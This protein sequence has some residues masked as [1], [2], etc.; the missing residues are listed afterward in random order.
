MWC[1]RERVAL[2]VPQLLVLVLAYVAA[3]MCCAGRPTGV[4]KLMTSSTLVKWC[5]CG[6]RVA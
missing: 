2:A 1:R 5:S 3:K 4:G 6:A